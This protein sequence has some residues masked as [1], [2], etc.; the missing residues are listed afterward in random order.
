MVMLKRALAPVVT[1][2]V[3]KDQ[4]TTFRKIQ[5]KRSGNN[6]RTAYS[7]TPDK[8]VLNLFDPNRYVLTHSSII[9]S[10]DTESVPNVDL[11]E[12]LWEKGRR[13]TRLWDDYRITKA[14]ERY[15]N[16]N[17]D[18]W[19]KQ[20]LLKT[21]WTFIGGYN[22]Q[23]HIQDPE[24]SKGILLD[25]VARDLGDTIYI[26]LLV[27]TDRVHTQ[28]VRDIVKGKMKT[29]SMGCSIQFS[30][31]THCGNVATDEDHMCTHI[32]LQKGDTF[33]DESGV[34]RKIAELCGHRDVPDSVTFFEASWVEVPAF[35]GAHV[36]TVLYVPP[37]LDLDSSIHQAMAISSTQAPSLASH[38][39]SW[40]DSFRQDALVL[41]ATFGNRA[42][43]GF[44]GGGDD[45]G[46]EAPKEE[47]TYMEEV[48]DESK[49]LIKDRLK[50]EIKQELVKDLNK[51][52]H[53]KAKNQDPKPEGENANDNIIHATRKLQ[54]EIQGMRLEGT[55]QVK[56]L[57]AALRLLTSK[58]M[59]TSTVKVDHRSKVYALMAIDRM[60]GLKASSE[61]YA[62]LLKPE[63]KTSFEKF[64]KI[65]EIHLRRSLTTGERHFLSKRSQ[66]LREN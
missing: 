46:E 3:H 24:L 65:C 51:K 40:M 38:S 8:D 62:L 53:D 9:A 57:H 60:R 61:Y 42:A 54:G 20:L 64:A 59:K 49:Q 36:R 45:E 6:I 21:F 58:N 39:A 5:G 7:G 47:K 14:T 44:G 43:F 15:L 1:R 28:L 55:T 4:W 17:G 13:I 37:D 2:A 66:M 33:V 26:D 52:D 22:Y 16:Y 32:K 19:E 27:A 12:D 11:G 30:L 41:S 34:E 63:S 31:C 10:V 35:D 23:E 25:A 48:L 50:L 18:A 56:V 29:M